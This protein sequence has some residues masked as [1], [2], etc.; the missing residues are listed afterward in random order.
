MVN[1]Q[2]RTLKMVSIALTAVALLGAG[3]IVWLV[4]V[5]MLRFLEE[6]ERFR[7]WMNAQ[8]S[9]STVIYVGMVM[10][11]VVLAV[12]PGEPVEIGGG[13]AF[14]FWMGTLLCVI[15]TV[16]GSMLVFFLVR[17]FGVKVVELFFPLEKINSLRFLANDKRRDTLAFLIFL[18][19]GTPK[20]MMTYFVGLTP[21]K[22][23]TFLFMSMVARLPS[24]VTSTAGGSAL[25]S[26][27][28]ITAVA[29]FGVTA[30]ISVGGWL[31]Y[32]WFVNRRQQ[33]KTLADES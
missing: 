5:P 18:F 32:K 1:M 4:G 14:G 31:L 24:I 15:G 11:Q 3:V 25:G 30:L 6:P 13:Y 8:G 23:S 27:E 2:K 26:Q 20:D 19:P 10:F 16:L 33:K 7:L 22:W 17:V 9:W 21:M 28:Y 12:V 29:V